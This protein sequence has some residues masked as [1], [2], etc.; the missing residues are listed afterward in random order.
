MSC[1]KKKAAEGEAQSGRSGF[2][3]MV[4]IVKKNSS[5]RKGMKVF[6][7]SSAYLFWLGS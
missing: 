1:G 4:V 2:D 3:E 6:I 5:D 7:P